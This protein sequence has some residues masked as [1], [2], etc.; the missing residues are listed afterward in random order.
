MLVEQVKTHDD[1]LETM[2]TGIQPVLDYVSLEQHEGARLSGDGPYRSVMDCCQM[3]WMN[4]KEF[5]HS[6][7]HGAIIHTLTQLWSHYPSVDL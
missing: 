7:A 3:G 2:I 4:F 5:A 6:T 1:M